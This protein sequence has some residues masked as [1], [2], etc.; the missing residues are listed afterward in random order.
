MPLLHARRLSRTS[1]WTLQL[2]PLSRLLLRRL[3][4]LSTAKNVALRREV[5]RKSK[6]LKVKRLPIGRLVLREKEGIRVAVVSVEVK[7][8]ELSAVVKR[9]MDSICGKRRVPTPLVKLLLRRRPNSEL[10]TSKKSQCR[11]IQWRLKSKLRK[12]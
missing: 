9:Q 6:L 12:L 11:V 2:S 10:R 4:L 5:L 1:K 8:A 3:S 7:Y